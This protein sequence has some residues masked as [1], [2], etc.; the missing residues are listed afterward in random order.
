MIN[1]IEPNDL[2]TSIGFI[3]G[4]AWRLN[5]NTGILLDDTWVPYDDQDITY[6]EVLDVHE[7]VR[8]ICNDIGR[9][10]FADEVMVIGGS[11]WLVFSVNYSFYDDVC[12]VTVRL[13][14]EPD[15]KEDE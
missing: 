14:E 4:K 15:N 1:R 10:V 8:E 2:V 3:E 9:M 11:Q 5:V 7:A 6:I 12:V 13:S